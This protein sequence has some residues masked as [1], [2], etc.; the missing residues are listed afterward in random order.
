M[1]SSRVSTRLS[2]TKRPPD[3]IWIDTVA[4]GNG[5]PVGPAT[6][7]ASWAGCGYSSVASGVASVTPTPGGAAAGFGR[8]GAMPAASPRS[9]G[10][11]A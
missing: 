9:S 3:A 4:P 7:P 11:C 8:S 1:P 6:R 10:S 2:V 5:A